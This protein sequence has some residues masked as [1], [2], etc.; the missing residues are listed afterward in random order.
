MAKKI[1]DSD[2]LKCSTCEDHYGDFRIQG[3]LWESVVPDKR[4]RLCIP[5]LEIHLCR[6]LRIEDFTHAD[7]NQ[8]LLLMHQRGY[9]RGRIDMH[10]ERRR[11]LS[12]ALSD[13]AD[14]ISGK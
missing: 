9:E 3:G 11:Q 4:M 1:V 8:P 2:S 6:E 7:C 10:E 12:S 5:C 13:L 14:I